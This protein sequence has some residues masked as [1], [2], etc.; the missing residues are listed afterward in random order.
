ME[1]QRYLHNYVRQGAAKRFSAAFPEQN[2][3]IDASLLEEVSLSLSLSLSRSL[4]MRHAFLEKTIFC[5][6]LPPRPSA[7]VVAKM[8]TRVQTA[9]CRSIS[10]QP[11]RNKDEQH[12]SE[13]PC[14]DVV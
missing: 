14:R 13:N 10:V 7:S 1:K 2:Q 8:N 12:V 11:G 6:I 4:S 5:G 9:R 3:R